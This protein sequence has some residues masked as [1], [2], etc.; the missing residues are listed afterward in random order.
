VERGEVAVEGVVP[1]RRLD[2]ASSAVL[3]VPGA[4]ESA[5]P[6]PVVIAPATIVAPRSL[7]ID[8]RST[9]FG[10]FQSVP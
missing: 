8:I 7:D 10:C 3:D 6:S 5:A 1:D 2:M 4:T 9:S